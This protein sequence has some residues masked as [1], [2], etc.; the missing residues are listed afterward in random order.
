MNDKAAKESLL[1]V[2]EVLNELKIKFWLTWGTL[3]GAVRDKGFIPWDTHIDLK[4]FAEG[5]NPSVLGL[6]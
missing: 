3:L 1:E 2:K 4:M 5:W 6:L